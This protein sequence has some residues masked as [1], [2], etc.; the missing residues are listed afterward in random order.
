VHYVWAIA[1]AAPWLV[2]QRLLVEE[3]ADRYAAPAM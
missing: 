2:E 1:A 3:G